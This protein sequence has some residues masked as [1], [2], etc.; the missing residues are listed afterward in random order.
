MDFHKQLSFKTICSVCS[1]RVT[2]LSKSLPCRHCQSFIHKKCGRLPNWQL[3]DIR[4]ILENW[5]CSSCCEKIFPFYSLNNFEIIAEGFNSNETCPCATITQEL[6]ELELTETVTEL[7]FNRLKINT[8]HPNSNNDIDENINLKCNFQYYSTHEFH[9]LQRKIKAFRNT[10][11]SMMQT[12]I[13]SLNKNINNLG[14]LQT[15]LGHSFDIIALSEAWIS[16]E[17]ES[18]IKKI[19]WYSWQ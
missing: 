14:I 18:T 7:D 2:N 1:R 12:N 3:H 19:L 4:A 8:A 16:K 11:F 5:Y 10:P 6:T 9:K 15:T 17:N 13:R